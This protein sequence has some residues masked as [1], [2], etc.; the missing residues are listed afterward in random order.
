MEVSGKVTFLLKSDAEPITKSDLKI[1]EINSGLSAN[2]IMDGNIMEN[3]LKG[4][5]KDKKWLLKTL[6]KYGYNKVDNIFLMV[7]NNNNNIAIYDKDVSINKKV[8]E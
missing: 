3:N 2:L 1:K 7:C 4:F 8:L 5:G 6:K